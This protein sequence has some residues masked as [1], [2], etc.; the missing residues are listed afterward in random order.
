MNFFLLIL[1]IL[2]AAAVVSA[3]GIILYASVLQARRPLRSLYSERTGQEDFIALD[4]V[5]PQFVHFILQT[6]D[7]EF[8][9]HHGFSGPAIRD[10]LLLNRNAR[11]I[12]TGG[13]TMTQQLVKNLYFRFYQSYIRKAAEA[14][15]TLAAERKLGKKKILELYLNIIYFGNGIYGLTHAS[16]FYFRKEPGQLTMNQMFLLACIVNAPTRGNPVQYPET[17]ERIRNKRLGLLIRRGTISPED[18]ELIRS[19]RAECLDGELRE[20]D[21]FTRQYPR[22]ICM[23]NYRFG[24]CTDPDR[25][26]VPPAAV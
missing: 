17:F 3:A 21:A 7:N 19:H 24:P 8:Y 22:E 2:S 25:V 23:A 14:V 15:I 16:R 20:N 13:S 26:T 4:A 5:P 9:E 18:A 10:A 6:E 11:K 1:L 12:V